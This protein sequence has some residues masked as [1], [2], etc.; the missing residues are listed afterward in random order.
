MW[1][2][3]VPAAGGRPRDRLR[4]ALDH[5]RHRPVRRSAGAC[6]APASI[7]RSTPRLAA[8]ADAGLTVADIDGIATY[9][10]PMGRPARRSP[11]RARRRC[12]TRC[13]SRSSWHTGGIEGAA[14]A[15]GRSS[16]PCMAVAR[17]AGQPRARATA[18]SP[19]RPRRVTGA[20]RASACGAAA[21]AGSAVSCSGTCRSGRY[22]GGE[23]AGACTPSGTS[24]SSARPASSWPDRAEC[25]RE[26]GLNP[27]AIYRDPMTMDD[28]L[29][30][31]MI[32]TPLCLFDCDVPVDGSH[33]GHRVARRHGRR[34]STHPVAHVEA[35]GHRA[36]RP[37]VLGPVRRPDH[38][39]GRATPPRSCGR[40]PT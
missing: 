9:P 30:A 17:R 20:V 1:H 16:T 6:T 26:R 5:L 33:R 2:P 11:G 25:P 14:P 4:A 37:T 3:A 13:G 22:V 24:T 23:L 8:I 19:R 29:A 12:R 31:R 35:V 10:G 36:A 34:P 18:R 38:D 27:N 40:A 21:A 32:S 39:G 15:R 7:S 28:Y